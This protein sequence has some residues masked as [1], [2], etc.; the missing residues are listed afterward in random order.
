M[1]TLTKT[2]VVI[3]CIFAL[4]YTVNFYYNNS[5]IN[6]EAVRTTIQ[7]TLK[8]LKL[9]DIKLP[10]VTKEKQYIVYEPHAAVYPGDPAVVK[11]TETLPD[12][13]ILIPAE[14]I[15]NVGYTFYLG[16]IDYA[17][18]S[19]VNDDLKTQVTN[20][21]N[22]SRFPQSLL[23]NLSIIFVNS[24]AASPLMYVETPNGW[25]KVNNFSPDFLSEGGFYAQYYSDAA[26]IFLN[27]Q[28]V[29]DSTN[30]KGVLTHELGHGIELQMNDD[31]W[32][33]YYGL[34]G[35]PTKTPRN[36]SSWTSSPMEDFAE[37]YKNIFTGSPIATSYGLLSGGQSWDGKESDWGPCMQKFME[38]SFMTDLSDAA[39]LKNAELQSC[40]RKNISHYRSVVDNKTKEFVMK[41]VDQLLP[42][43]MQS[44]KPIDFKAECVKALNAR[45]KNITSTQIK[46]N[47]TTCQA[48]FEEGQKRYQEL[49]NSLKK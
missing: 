48:Q 23:N 49:L 38:L 2:I 20:I 36:G 18:S 29:N 35:I 33:L 39:I 44:P 31:A 19:P 42:V 27:K 6:D 3:I 37:V 26:I 47:Q 28:N 9:T 22:T 16:A 1:K 43:T 7:H 14:K 30:L 10:G 24:L 5:L 41:I 21:I 40:R 8:F 11:T 45:Y 32:K 4:G 17:S 12:S 46:A 25:I 13:A 34:R 15:N